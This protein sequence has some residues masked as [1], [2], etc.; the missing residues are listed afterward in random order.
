MNTSR[1]LPFLVV[2]DRQI[3]ENTW[4]NKTSCGDNERSRNVFRADPRWSVSCHQTKMDVQT[5]FPAILYHPGYDSAEKRFF[6]LVSRV[7][8]LCSEV[9]M[10]HKVKSADNHLAD[11]RALQK[12]GQLLHRFKLRA[13]PNVC[14]V[15]VRKRG[16]QPFLGLI[17]PGV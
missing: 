10:R 1:P 7:E 2:N 3:S 13:Q 15:Y 12:A 14:H 9:L 16:T 11:S 8:S 5:S 4:R 17:Q 6:F